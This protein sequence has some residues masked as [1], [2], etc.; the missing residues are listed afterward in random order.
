MGCGEL[1]GGAS[2]SLPQGAFFSEKSFV[3]GWRGDKQDVYKRQ[4]LQYADYGYDT[5]TKT[6]VIDGELTYLP[7]SEEWK[8]FIAYITKLYQ[9][10]LMDKNSFTQKHEQ[11]AAIGQSGDV[12]GTF[13]D[14][15]AFLAVGRDNDDDY[16]LLTPFQEGTFPNN[17]G[18]IPGTL[19]ITDACEHPEVII[20]WADQFYS[21][22]GGILA[23]LGV[24]GKTYQINE[25]GDWEWIVGGEYGDDIATVRSKATIQGAQKDVYKRQLEQSVINA[26]ADLEDG[27]LVQEVVEGEDAYYVVRLDKKLD[28]EATANKKE[29]IISERE[30]EQYDKLVEDWTKD[31]KLKVEKNVWKKV[32]VTDSVSFQYKACL[33][34]TSNI[35]SSSG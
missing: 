22:E 23:W 33:L 3:D 6:A 7:T 31:S 17:T 11:Q 15:G 32:E 2:G 21:E 35:P 34:Y 20:A 29:S 26:V 10:G 27:Q 8:E 1:A 16:I 30:Q 12:L 24:E 19:A 4:L 25:K 28:E 9:E 13:F 14:A 5:A 18:V